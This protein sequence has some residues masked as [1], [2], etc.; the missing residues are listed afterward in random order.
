MPIFPRKKPK[1]KIELDSDSV[2]LITGGARGITAAIATEIGA[3][4]KSH[5][6][7]MGRSPLPPAK[8]EDDTAP[9]TS[10]AD[11]KKAI[12]AAISAEGTK[13]SPSLVE[14]RYKKII[15][16]REVRQNIENIKATGASVEYH[17]V[18][19]CNRKQL[20]KAC[21]SI[22]KKYHKID[23][24][25]HGAGII[26]DKLLKDKSP[27]S[28]DR[29]FATKVQSSY[30]LAEILKPESLKF[31]SFFA[32]I[33]SRYG[34][35]GQSDYAAANEVL[36]KLATDLDRRWD[37]RV[38]AVAWGPWTG[39]GMVSDLEK[40]LTAR[41]IALIDQATGCRMFVEEILY[42]KKGET[43]IIIA[44]GAENMITPSTNQPLATATVN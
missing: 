36:C 2:V 16:E 21:K 22:Y 10:P 37:A 33:A 13:P 19:V 31:A 29:V 1:Q 18:D 26:D 27:E 20:E 4:F 30:A 25:I 11:L 43:E 9:H 24:V 7:L 12:M 8:E 39:I 17:S 6:I 38:F 35:R 3:Q 14:T 44:G 32:S 5:L 15:T 42:G 40:H 28:F 34:N 23:G 41:G